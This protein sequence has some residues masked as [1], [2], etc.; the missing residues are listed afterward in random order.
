MKHMVCLIFL[1]F[2]IFIN[3]CITVRQHQ[4]QFQDQL[5]FILQEQKTQAETQLQIQNNLIKLEKLLQ[6]MDKRLSAVVIQKFE[7][8]P[9]TQAKIS[10]LMESQGINSAISTGSQ[11][12]FQFLPPDNFVRGKK[13]NSP[14]NDDVEQRLTHLEKDFQKINSHPEI[15]TEKKRETLKIESQKENIEKREKKLKNIPPHDLYA[16]ALKAFNELE[17]PIALTLWD[18]MTDNFPEHKLVSNAF[19]WQG[20]AHY[21]MQ[22]FDNAMLKYNKVIEKY[23]ESSKYPPALLKAGLSCFALNKNKEGELR[24]KELIEKFP[25]RAEAKRAG[26]F[27]HKR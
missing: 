12:A 15:T 23:A 3:G 19:F 9:S 1:F 11:E 10:T 4:N 13:E 18:E 20:E 7:S 2:F 6:E 26:I 22:D 8:I 27:L 17:Y 24:L 14:K 21:Q 16:Q 5:S 25:D